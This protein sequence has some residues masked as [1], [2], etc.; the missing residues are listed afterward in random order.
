MAE[1]LV[2]MLQRGESSQRGYNDYN[3][4]AP[5][6]GGPGHFRGSD[7]E[8]DFSQVTIDEI[9]AAQRLSWDDPDKLHAVG[10]YQIIGNTLQGAIR[11]MGLSGNE[12]FTPDMQDRILANYLLRD[13]QPSIEAYVTGQPGATLRAAQVGMANEWASVAHPDTGAS[14]YENNHASITVAQSAAALEG[15]RRQYADAIARG[16]TP[17]EAWRRA[18]G[19]GQA[20]EQAP[21]GQRQ[22]QRQEDAPR[23]QDGAASPPL[24]NGAKGEAVGQLQRALAG[25]G[26]VGRDGQPLAADRDFGS[27]TDHAVREFQRAH[28]LEVDGKVGRDTRTALAQAAERPLVSEATHPS[29]GLYRAIAGQLPEG[30]DPKVV[31]NVTLQAMENGIDSPERLRGVA[32]RGNDVHLQGAVAGERVTIDM[33]AP[34]ADLQAMSDHMRGQSAERMQ[35]Q[36]REQQQRREPQTMTA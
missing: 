7:R 15:A 6:S 27:N 10:R 12:R 5:R 13:K 21:D 26:Y 24:R 23:S 17:D 9:R 4:Y 14:V 16:A 20:R 35:E 11:N 18:S 22:D 30:T 19:L 2:E 31:A 34:T 8:I 36:Q 3:R 33:R 29:N 32:V 28:G 25:L 1:S